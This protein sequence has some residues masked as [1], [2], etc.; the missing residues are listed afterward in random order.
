MSSHLRPRRTVVPHACCAPIRRVKRR[1]SRSMDCFPLQ[2][3]VKARLLQFVGE[4]IF[5]KRMYQTAEGVQRAAREVLTKLSIP[6]G[7][8]LP[9]GAAGAYTLL[10]RHECRCVRTFTLGC[11]QTTMP[12]EACLTQRRLFSTQH[13][14]ADSI[15]F[16]QQVCL[17]R[18]CFSAFMLQEF[19]LQA[20]HML[21]LCHK[22]A[23]LAGALGASVQIAS[24]ASRRNT[25]GAQAALLQST[26]LGMP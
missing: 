8:S 19:M 2:E 22:L 9:D 4:P 17:S 14:A 21:Y 11:V 24:S 3:Y 16:C 7:K 1:E 20:R 25:D 26:C 6:A 12:M 15:L 5:A 10:F 23:A 18:Q 13:L